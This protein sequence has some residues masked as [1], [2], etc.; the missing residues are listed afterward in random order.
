MLAERG[1]RGVGVE[2]DEEM[3]RVARRNLGPYPSWRVDVSDFELWTP[4]PEDEAFDLVTVAQA[5][6][7]IDRD[8]GAAQ[9]QRL[10]RPGGWLAIFAHEP[11]FEDSRLRRAIDAVYDELA[12]QPFVASR[13]PI[14]KIP[15]SAAF[16]RPIER[17]FRGS[18]DYTTRELI[19]LSRTHSDKLILPPDRRERLL[20]RLAEVID[21][22]GGVCREHYVCKLWAAQRL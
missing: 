17:E 7:W 19:D 18:Y 1:L 13:A 10:L 8:A 16:G 6:H 12:P 14:E 21:E 9:A 11:E 5:W 20:A 4:R 3:A 22:H 15:V 2:P